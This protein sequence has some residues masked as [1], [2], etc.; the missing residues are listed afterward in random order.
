MDDVRAAAIATAFG[1][2]DVELE[3]MGGG[4]SGATLAGFTIDGR[5]FVIRQAGPTRDAAGLTRELACLRIAADHGLAPRVVHA[6]PEAHVVITERIAGAPIGRH[7]PRDTDPLGRLAA[8]LRALHATPLFPP[9]PGFP[10]MFAHLERAVVARGGQP[11]PAE[12]AGAIAQVG[13]TIERAPRVSCHLDLNPTNIL[14][15]ADRVYLVD[16][17]IA[18]A[19]DAFVDLAQLGVWVCRDA[20]E[21]DALLAAYLERAPSAADHAHAHAARI[22]ALA[23]YAAAFHLVSAF[24]GLAVPATPLRLA[25]VIVRQPFAPNDM[26]AALLGELRAER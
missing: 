26:A 17:E 6:D 10:A 5:G 7:T 9:G 21:R 24:A 15:T 25:D 19:N 1:R 13:P 11:L 22:L 2:R 3:P 8:T 18:C 23:F 20:G 4:R 14:A 16:W 12:L